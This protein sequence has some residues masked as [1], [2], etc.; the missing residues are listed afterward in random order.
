[1]AT[2]G[3]KTLESIWNVVGQTLAEDLDSLFS[4]QSS[5][6]VFQIPDFAKRSHMRLLRE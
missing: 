4:Y 2:L 3:T 6:P 1:M 5:T